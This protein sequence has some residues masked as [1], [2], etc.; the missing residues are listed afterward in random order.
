LSGGIDSALV[1]A[2]AA[3]ALGP[4]NVTGVSMPSE[5]SSAGSKDDA[6]ALADNL[7][8]RYLTIPIQEPFEALKR[9][10]AP[11]FA[12]RENAAGRA[13]AEQNLQAR[14]R[15]TILM[16]LSNKEGSLLVSTGNKSELSVGYC[17]LYG[18]M[19]GGLALLADVPKKTVYE[20]SRWL[21]RDGVVIPQSSIDKAPSAELKP[22]QK[23]QDDLPPYDV[24]DDV[25]AAY[26]ERRESVA[27]IAKKHGAAVTSDLLKRID[28]AEYKRRQAPPC[29]KIS[30]KAFGV[31]RRMP[32]ARA[33]YRA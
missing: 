19:C 3:R 2:L 20:L 16:S 7:G 28:R 29:I 5:F 13:A 15:G 1:G 23:D 18:D 9:V 33:S 30:E 8:L 10:L 31:G 25:L 21:N 12:E 24:V 22:D 11:A 32:I 27:A 26:V 17:T 14:L 4:E 6:K